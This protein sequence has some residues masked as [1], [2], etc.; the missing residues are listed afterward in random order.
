MGASGNPGGAAMLSRVANAIYWMTRYVERADNVARFADVNLNLSLD[1]PSD[2]QSQWQ[3]LVNTTGD[4]QWFGKRYGQATEENVIRFLTIDGDYPNSILSSLRFARENARTIRE[5]ISSEMWEHLNSLY[6]F[7]NQNA[8]EDRL[9]DEAYNFFKRIKMSCHLFGALLDHTMSHTEAWNFARLGLLMERADKTSRILDIKYFIL[10]PEI[11]DVG[12]P[13]DTIQ[14]SALLKSAS[15]LEMY[16]K[17]SRRITSDRVAEFLLLNREF[18]R[19]IHF[20][21]SRMLESL[22]RI[23]GTPIHTFSNP[24]EKETG[25]LCSDLDYANI[26]DIVDAGLHEYLD[27]F[28]TRLNEIDR[29][30]Y[31]QFFALAPD[32]SDSL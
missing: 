20:C 31:E 5:I 21:V 22:H 28:Q 7:V 26:E 17:Q 8:E 3:P 29:R 12:T 25:K 2:I 13:F 10:L 1:M 24:V 15:A 6:L 30:I 14:W 9:V 23:S 16:R 19:S 27:N 4:K 32:D 18:P 11:E